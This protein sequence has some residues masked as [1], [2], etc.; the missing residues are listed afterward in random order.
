MSFMPCCATK[1]NTCFP[2][3]FVLSHFESK[4]LTIIY[5]ISRTKLYIQVDMILTTILY[6]NPFIINSKILYFSM[7]QKI[8][9]VLI[10]FSFPI[11]IGR[12]FVQNIN[13]VIKPLLLI[14]SIVFNNFMQFLT[15]WSILFKG[16]IRINLG[17]LI[18]INT[19]RPNPVLPI[20]II[21]SRAS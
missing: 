6:L 8:K 20:S 13:K 19:F 7:L 14:C 15:L 18:I 17:K 4:I 16:T 10:Q 12:H 11:S 9:L 2:T 5:F 21:K 3:I 1:N